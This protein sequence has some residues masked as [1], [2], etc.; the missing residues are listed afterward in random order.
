MARKPASPPTNLPARVPAEVAAEL[1]AGDRDARAKAAGWITAL[2]DQAERGDRDALK[3]AIAVYA[4]V[5]SLWRHNAAPLR[6]SLERSLLD[7]LVPNDRLFTREAT[8]RELEAMRADLLG[9]EPTALER[10]L[11]DRVV[12]DWLAA[13]EADTDRAGWTGG[14]IA[15]GEYR[16]RR[17]DRAHGRLMRSLKTLAA[18]R[19]LVGPSVQIN[20]AER[21]QQVNVPG[22]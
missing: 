19:R 4:E 17:A 20:V 11:V 7:R 3:Q 1:A 16:E 8:R 5:P 15:D 12:V 10:V 9:D 18:V 2:I 21:I 14:T 13:L 22:G 6:D